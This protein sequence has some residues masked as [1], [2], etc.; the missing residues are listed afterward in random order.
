MYLFF[1]KAVNPAAHIG[2][3]MA[4]L[5]THVSIRSSA[6]GKLLHQPKRQSSDR[7]VC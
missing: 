1:S 6:F 2:S 7:D 3:T 5:P 4:P